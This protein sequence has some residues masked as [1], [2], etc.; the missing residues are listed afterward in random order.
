MVW[1]LKLLP[2]QLCRT[3]QNQDELEHQ[4]KTQVSKLHHQ[5]VLLKR[6][7]KFYVMSFSVFQMHL[8]SYCGCG[9]ESPLRRFMT[10][11]PRIMAR[12]VRPTPTW[13]L[14]SRAGSRRDSSWPRDKL[15]L[16]WKKTEHMYKRD[17]QR[18]SVKHL[19]ETN[20]VRSPGW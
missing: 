11:V 4:N 10:S 1:A 18:Q 12:L 15:V 19:T 14:K 20:G 3:S 16:S 13:Q 5:T 8:S 6:A 9:C 7:L 2:P 17:C